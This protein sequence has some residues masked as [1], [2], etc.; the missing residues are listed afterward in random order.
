MIISPFSVFNAL[1]LLAQGAG[2]Q[3]F[4]QLATVLGTGNNKK[5]TATQ[6]KAY[7]DLLNKAVGNST[8][9]LANEIYVQTGYQLNQQYEKVAVNQFMSGIEQLNFAD[10]TASAQVINQFVDNKTDGKIQNLISP[11]ML[12]AATRLFLVN[13]IYFKGEWLHQF[14]VANTYQGNF[15]TKNSVALVDF[16]TQTN[17][18]NYGNIADLDATA[19]EL[20]YAYSNLSFVILLPNN[21]NCMCQLSKKLQTYT[22]SDYAQI[23]QSMHVEEVHVTIPKFTNKFS[24]GMND[25]L[26]EVCIARLPFDTIFQ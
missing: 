17:H 23:T 6:F 10:A 25:V 21:P 14:D 4:Q 22:A 24:I 16:M 1:A 19:L 5:L 7:Y 26:A 18:F 9:S 13:A 2:G 8:F 15:T 12:S 20:Q 3:T 11:D